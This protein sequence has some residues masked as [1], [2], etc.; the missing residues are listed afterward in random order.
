MLVEL[1]G[2]G[3]WTQS[4]REEVSNLMEST[5]DGLIRKIHTSNVKEVF[6]FLFYDSGSAHSVPSYT[7]DNYASCSWD[8]AILL[9]C[10]ALLV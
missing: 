1:H 6:F 5:T 10:P 8:D 4:P 9:P 3:L 7:E 2:A